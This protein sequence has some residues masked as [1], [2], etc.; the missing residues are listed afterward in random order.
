MALGS[1][2]WSSLIASLRRR[3]RLLQDVLKGI[4]DDVEL[5]ARRGQLQHLTSLVS[6]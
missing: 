6:D 2:P 3:Q 5:F 4:I 1:S